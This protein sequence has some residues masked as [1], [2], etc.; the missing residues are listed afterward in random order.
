MEGRLSVGLIEPSKETCDIEFLGSIP[1]ED[2]KWRS[3]LE[4]KTRMKSMQAR[5]KCF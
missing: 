4:A 2:Y 5:R 1:L 3:R